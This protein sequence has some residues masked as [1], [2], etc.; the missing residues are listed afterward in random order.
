MEHTHIKYIFYM[1][2]AAMKIMQD[3][4]IEM[5]NQKAIT[6]TNCWGC[7]HFLIMNKELSKSYF[8]FK[9]LNG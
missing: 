5:G 8:Y 1:Y 7:K 6:F 3:H 4:V 2:R 9:I